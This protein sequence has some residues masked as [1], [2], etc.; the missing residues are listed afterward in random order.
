MSIVERVK[1]FGI[2]QQH[3]QQL[4]KNGEYMVLLTSLALLEIEIG[5]DHPIALDEFCDFLQSQSND[6]EH[7]YRGIACE[8]FDVRP[9]TVY[10]F[11]DEIRLAQEKLSSE[12]VPAE[13]KK[14]LLYHAHEEFSHFVK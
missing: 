13:E 4:W 6:A 2:S 9:K 8:F 14:K 5:E 3:N 1:V 7:T 12:N 10:D 11:V